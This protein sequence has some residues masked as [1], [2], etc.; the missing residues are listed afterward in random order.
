MFK[1]TSK[2]KLCN[3]L[4]YYDCARY[5]RGWKNWVDIPKNVVFIII[6]SMSSGLL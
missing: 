1:G 6:I 4:K 3:F 5:I 2:R